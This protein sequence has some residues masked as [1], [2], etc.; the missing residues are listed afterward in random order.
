M[1]D[2]C[3]LLAPNDQCQVA[4][5]LADS[6]TALSTFGSTAFTVDLMA[7][8]CGCLG[9][10]GLVSNI[11]A[12]ILLPA[13]WHDCCCAC[14]CCCF[15]AA[16]YVSVFAFN[17]TRTS[18]TDGMKATDFIV[19]HSYVLGISVDAYD[20]LYIALGIGCHRV[21]RI[22][23]NNDTLELIA[24]TGAEGT[25]PH[26]KWWEREAGEVQLSNEGSG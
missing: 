22:R 21:L 5:C 4:E 23:A 25:P 17:G 11:P 8:Y 15:H 6:L 26:W 7:Q 18:F 16:C 14:F 20:N 12:C 19:P 3:L 2:N 13:G 10:F 9:L 1:Y 24:G